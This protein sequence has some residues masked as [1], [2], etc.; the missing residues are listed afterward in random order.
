MPQS[1]LHAVSLSEAL[2]RTL[3]QRIL[4]GEIAPGTVLPEVEVAAT[5]GVARPT[6]RAA[7][8]TLV[9][10]GLLRREANRSAYVP[11]LTSED[12]RDLFFVRAALEAEAVRRLVERRVRPTG[13]EDAVRWLEAADGSAE[14]SEVV[15]ADLDFHSALIEAVGSERLVRQYAL[16]QDEIRLSLAQLRTAYGSPA[17]LAREHRALL[18]SIAAGE[19]DAAATLLNDHLDA[20]VAA[21]APEDGR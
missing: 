20:A 3:R 11:T 8:Q 4:S 2:A 15:D 1:L 17:E 5:Y 16:L 14:W 7:L 19:P 10:M 21:L 12:I 9:G 6:V 13:A 18:E